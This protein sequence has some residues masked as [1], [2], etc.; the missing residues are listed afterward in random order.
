MWDTWN[1]QNLIAFQC[2]D[3]HGWTL[4]CTK[5]K[6]LWDDD[7]CSPSLVR[8]GGPRPIQMRQK[9]E[10]QVPTPHHRPP[11]RV[12]Y[13]IGW[14]NLGHLQNQNL[15]A[16]SHSAPAHW[17]L[18]H[19]QAFDQCCWNLLPDQQRN[20]RTINW[21]DSE[22]FMA[23][24]ENHHHHPISF[25]PS[26]KWKK[27][28]RKR[29]KRE[30]KRRGKRQHQENFA[31]RQALL[32]R[33]KQIKKRKITND[34]KKMIIMMRM[35]QL[36]RPSRELQRKNSQAC[37]W[38]FGFCEVGKH[39]GCGCGCGGGSIMGV[40]RMTLWI[41]MFCKNEQKPKILQSKLKEKWYF[42]PRGKKM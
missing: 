3:H 24:S 29:A 32:T 9:E 25:I 34:D 33:W 28:K 1:Q 40:E 26:S 41:I 5:R 37:P 19:S 30:R 6:G 8:A 38:P 39:Y 17:N 4:F 22:G 42:W 21:I 14:L 10:A 7:A 31:A 27:R 11:S 35:K 13:L 18:R 2:W 16:Q 15:E 36:C 12:L 23:Q 20:K